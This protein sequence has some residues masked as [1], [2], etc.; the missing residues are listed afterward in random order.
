MA[1]FCP[2]FL[3]LGAQKCA[4]TW[5]HATLRAQEGLWLP[6]DKEFPLLS[7]HA[8]LADPGWQRRWNERFRDAP[9]DGLIGDAC[10]R[11]LWNDP[12][13]PP[14]FNPDIPGSVKRLFGP[15]IRLIVL[16]RD[17]VERAIS[18]YLHHLR[19]GSLDWNTRLFD[20]PE[21]LGI[22]HLG[23]YR[24]H[25]QYWRQAFAAD[26]LLVLAA[27]PRKPAAEVLA[28]VLRFLDHDRPSNLAG[29][30]S[31]IFEGMQ[32]WTDAHGGVWINP[33]DPDLAHQPPPDRALPRQATGLRHQL[34]VISPDEIARVRQFYQPDRENPDSEALSH[35][36]DPDR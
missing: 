28:A 4:T 9:P 3:I 31:P 24:A 7:Y 17:P 19:H 34:R 22:L 18:A 15:H 14:G 26:R 36:L 5:L 20:A 32:R 29:V 1:L 12:P 2:D 10:A 11:L 23:R 21:E 6:P 33:D 25:L 30:E 8:H 35:A 16:L 27:P 13:L